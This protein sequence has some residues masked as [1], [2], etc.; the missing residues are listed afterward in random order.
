MRSSFRGGFGKWRLRHVNST[1]RPGAHKSARP[2]PPRDESLVRFFRN[3]LLKRSPNSTSVAWL[4]SLSFCLDLRFADAKVQRCFPAS[5]L[6]AAPHS[7]KRCAASTPPKESSYQ[8]PT[9]SHP[10]SPPPVSCH[11]H[12][13]PQWS[14]YSQPA[15]VRFA[16][17]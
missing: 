13:A 6:A 7:A 1:L 4:C 14:A 9:L 8:T 10:F 2:N 17:Q 11:A 5:K 12:A 3:G 16:S 15:H